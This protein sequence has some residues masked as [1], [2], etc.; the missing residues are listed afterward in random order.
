MWGS[1]PSLCLMVCVQNVGRSRHPPRTMDDGC[2]RAAATGY[3]AAQRRHLA[4]GSRC[5]FSHPPRTT[6]AAAMEGAM[7]RA[8]AMDGAMQGAAADTA[9]AIA[10]TRTT[11]ILLC[12]VWI[13]IWITQPHAVA[14]HGAAA[15]GHDAIATDEMATGLACAMHCTCSH[16]PHIDTDC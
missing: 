10:C 13:W 6:M 11:I 12:D 7:H 4:V 5:T 8:A 16:A 3:G 2:A 9:R 1:I 14:P 15:T